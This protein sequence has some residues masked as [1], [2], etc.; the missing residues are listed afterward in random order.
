ARA[1]MVILFLLLLL[2]PLIGTLFLTYTGSAPYIFWMMLLLLC[3]LVLSALRFSSTLARSIELSIEA[4]FRERGLH[5][6]QQRLSLYVKETPLAVIEW[7]RALEVQAWNPAAEAIFGY[8]SDEAQGSSLP[9]LVFSPGSAPRLTEIWDGLTR[10]ESAG[11][12]LILENR[13]REGTPLICEWFNTQLG[14]EQGRTMGI[15]SLVQD[16]TQRVENERL[17]QEFV[18]IVSH[19][20]RTPVT[21]IK[22]GLSLLASG[23][24]DDDAAQ[25]RELLEMALQN[26]NRLQLLIND[27][28]DVD[29]LES[30]KMDFRFR[31][32]DLVTLLHDAAKANEGYARQFQVHLN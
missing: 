27:I 5:N 1:E 16:V 6:F 17:K 19:E 30:G 32:C 25:S 7:N 20:L 24:L 9:A 10:D 23:M 26:T 8:S 15:L 13:N 11:H 22:G 12:Q 14:D 3:L 18:S 31:D 29:K 2:S 28:L 21:S 4:A